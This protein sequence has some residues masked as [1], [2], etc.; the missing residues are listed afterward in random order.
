MR[1]RQAAAVAFAELVRPSDRDCCVYTR[2]VLRHAFGP[3]AVDAEPVQRWH[4]DVDGGRE[5]GIEVGPWGPVDAAVQAGLTV[6]SGPGAGERLWHWHLCQGWRATPLAPGSTGHTFLWFAQPDGWGELLDSTRQRGP[7][8][9]GLQRW[10]EFVSQ[11]RGGLAVAA[12]RR[13]A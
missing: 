3:E 10:S 8:L 11:F 1:I 9:A 4:L 6:G 13:A 2:K 5:E 12:L 7:R